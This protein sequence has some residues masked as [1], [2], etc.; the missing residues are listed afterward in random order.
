MSGRVTPYAHCCLRKQASDVHRRRV[1]DVVARI[2]A[3]LSIAPAAPTFA[4]SAA[5][6]ADA[7]PET[8]AAM[9]ED[10]AAATAELPFVPASERQQAKRAVPA[11]AAPDAIVV[12]GQGA[13]KKRKRVP[14]AKADADAP[15]GEPGETF[16]YAAVSNILDEGSDHER[17][18][19]AGGRRRRQ[20]TQGACYL[21][22]A[23]GCG[24]RVIAFF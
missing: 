20:K 23:L 15:E 2:H 17:D 7:A 10:A 21:T 14:A 24:G 1:R 6:T 9:G 5:A 18:A 11:E 3:S 8:D 16:D 13:R 12:V 4:P 22:V 19:A